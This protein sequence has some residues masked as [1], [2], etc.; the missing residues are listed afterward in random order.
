[1]STPISW[2]MIEP[3]WAV[4]TTGG[5]QVGTVRQIVGDPN[6]DIFDGLSVA[7]D[8]LSRPRYVP[9]EQVGTIVDGT[10]RIELTKE[11][12]DALDD[13]VEP[14]PVP[15][16]EPEQRDEQRPQSPLQRLFGRGLWRR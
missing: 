2:F 4:E 9:A 8:M 3:G 11:Q 16:R 15:E 1:M 5:E 7:I 14:P 12:F 10:V 13:Y 6:A